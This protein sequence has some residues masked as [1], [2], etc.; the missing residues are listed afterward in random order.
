MTGIQYAKAMGYR[1]I[2]IDVMDGPLEEAKAQGADH[3]FNP[4]KH[5]NYVAEIKA[6]TD[7]GCHA[8]A[9]FTA[10]KVAYDSS[11]AVLRTNGVLTVVGIPSQPIS[12]DALALST[13]G[14][15]V[16]GGSNGIPQQLAELVQF[17]ADHSIHPHVTFYPLEQLSHMIELLQSGKV[18]GR[19]AVRF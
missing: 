1:V 5:T 17:T 3:V 19:L 2:G 4:K 18:Q 14:F 11:P 6:L 12:L 7:G 13:R 15:R 8:V 16:R 10:S 9:N